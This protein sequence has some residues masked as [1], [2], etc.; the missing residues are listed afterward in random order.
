MN[1]KRLLILGIAGFFIG[2]VANAPA[3]LITYF[4]PAN[5]SLEG[6]AGTVWNGSARQLVVNKIAAGKLG[7]HVIPSSL[8]RARL[9]LGLDAQLP[10]GALSGRAAIGFGGFAQINDVKGSLPLAYLARD[11]P[12]GMLGGRV[13]LIIEQAELQDGWPTRIKGVVALGNLVQNIPKPMA[14][15]TYSASFDGSRADDGA[16][17]GLISTRSGPLQV[18]GELILAGNRS[19]ILESA[20]GATSDTPEDLKSMLPM[21][22]EQLPDGR[23]RLHHSGAL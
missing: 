11:F 12:A 6:V 4:L 14:L 8:L 18:D 3:R 5:V 19:Y 1:F 2:L 20:V 7:W 17:K 23:Y 10:D 21:V 22:G 13:S 16:I 9:E 15:G